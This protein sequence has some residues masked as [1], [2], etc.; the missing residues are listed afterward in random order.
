MNFLSKLEPKVI[1]S[2]IY[3]DIYWSKEGGF[4][5]KEYV[6]V[7][8]N[9]LKKR[10]ATKESF[11]IFEL[12]FGAG[13]NFLATKK[14]WDSSPRES[15]LHYIS[16]ELHPIPKDTLREILSEF[17]EVKEEREEFLK[18]YPEKFFKIHRLEFKSSKIF[19]TLWIGNAL[20]A[21][22]ELHF[23][24][25]AYFLDGFSPSKNPEM[26]SMEVFKQMR[27]HSKEFSTFSTYSVSKTV[28]ENA[29][30][31][32][33]EI[34]TQKGFGT[35]K[36]MLI[37]KLN[38]NSR[39]SLTKKYFPNPFYIELPK[40]IAILG[41]GISGLCLGYSFTLRAKKV[42]IL[43]ENFTLGE[44]ASS[45]PLGYF[46]PKLTKKP[47]VASELSLL[48]TIFTSQRL[49][50]WN[51]VLRKVIGENLGVN[52]YF[53]NVK[54]RED[55]LVAFQS[56]HLDRDL[57]VEKK[58]FISKEEK[59]CLHLILGGYFKP[60][61]FSKS[62]FEY[63]QAKG[64]EFQF[65]KKVR[66]I[67]FEKTWK[68]WDES[69]ILLHETEVLILANSYGMSDFAQVNLPLQKIRGQI[70][71]LPKD[72][73]YEEKPPFLV[74]DT[75][76]ISVDEHKLLGATFNPFDAD[77]NVNP[78]HSELLLS[79]LRNSI[80][81]V[82]F[83]DGKS[84]QARVGFRSNTRD[85]LPILGAVPIVEEYK[86]DYKNFQ[87]GYSDSK[88]PCGNVYPNL[89]IL[90][91]MGS[92]GISYAPI[93]AESL[94]SL[95]CGEAPPISIPILEALHPARFILRDI[96]NKKI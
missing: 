52:L 11:T 23:Y 82:P 57:L 4:Q 78:D 76:C 32:G 75:Y 70:C 42:T 61:E 27:L 62:M 39:E 25:D 66:K 44:N 91:G 18:Y 71:F 83:Y 48:G 95:I 93:L 6:F 38:L 51:E 1:Y 87:K 60:L 16:T 65:G 15:T 20:E 37:G 59:T 21:F 45:N 24:A 2:Q 63:L 50:V 41:A 68:L 26:W 92:K 19:L 53:Q 10:W 49:Q 40:T 33:F 7:E 43:D 29:I 12:G 81:S 84:L 8:G 77:P 90:G 89:Y 86:K 64:V 35:K 36:E 47:T 67:T 79:R 17:E 30:A 85:R 28:R 94:V 9:S 13:L 73:E 54:E 88:Y 80:S 5:E 14:A 3:Q 31:N 69:G 22:K 46:F 55:F 74:E 34:Q 72:F 58:V 56:H 96:M